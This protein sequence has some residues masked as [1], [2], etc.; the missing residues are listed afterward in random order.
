MPVLQR[1]SLAIDSSSSDPLDTKN[2][3]YRL[4]K[5]ADRQ[6]DVLRA[7]SRKGGAEVDPVIRAPVLFRTRSYTVS[8]GETSDAVAVHVALLAD[9]WLRGIVVVVMGV[10]DDLV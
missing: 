1:L 9:F 10:G 3:P 4:A 5:S 8:V 6:L 2:L 7:R